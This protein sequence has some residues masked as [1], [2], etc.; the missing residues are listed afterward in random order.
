MNYKQKQ[1]Y[2]ISEKRGF[3]IATQFIDKWHW[4]SVDYKFASLKTRSSF[5]D[6][7]FARMWSVYIW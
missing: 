2:T 6:L 5:C 4:D 3:Q 7:G 1:Q